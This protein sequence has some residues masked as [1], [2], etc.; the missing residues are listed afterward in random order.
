MK[1]SD[2]TGRARPRRT[3]LLVAPL[4]V[5]ALLTLAPA[6]Q[7]ALQDSPAWRSLQTVRDVLGSNYLW[8]FDEESA[9][10]GAI[11]GLVESLNDPFTEYIPPQELSVL[12]GSREGAFGGVGAVFY[13]VE[14]DPGVVVETYLGLPAHSAGLRPGDRLLAVDGI[15]VQELDLR[16][17]IELIRGPVGQQ[18]TFLVK[19]QDAEEPLEIAVTRDR[20]SIPVVSGTTLDGGVGYLRIETFENQLVIRQL[21]E[22]LD[23]LERSGID[24]LILD[25]RD[26][27]GG[28]LSQGVEVA[29]EFLS[30]GDILFVRKGGVTRRAFS[31]DA[32][33][34]DLPLVVLVNGNSA[35]ASEIVAAA[36]QDHERALIV[37]EQS[38]GKGVG[39]DLLPLPGGGELKYVSFEWLRPSRE[40]VH[41]TGVTPDLLVTDLRPSEGPLVFGS[42]ATPGAE[43]VIEIGGEVVGTAVVGPDGSFTLN[44]TGEANVTG[45]SVPGV[46]TVEPASDPILRA[47]LELLK[48][49]TE[50]AGRAT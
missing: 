37:G 34:R 35:S 21:R 30:A 47:A 44:P 40:S 48:T 50:V 36:L 43:V 5:A 11:T 8:E 25:L 19:R 24:R 33:A 41:E 31:A 38:F 2:D 10:R 39:Q 45:V 16:E 14:G 26:N 18:V 6:G 49:G 28:Y 29:D 1:G 9:L 15:E 23:E 46:A 20:I 27:G 4:L 22:R 42:S 3:L 13:K 17:S 12:E 7:V 32:F